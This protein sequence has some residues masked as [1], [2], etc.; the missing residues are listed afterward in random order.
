MTKYTRRK[1]RK[2]KEDLMRGSLIRKVGR[3]AVAGEVH[4][5]KWLGEEGRGR[6]IRRKKGQRN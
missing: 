1:R 6:G 5:E 3:G 4:E 2:E